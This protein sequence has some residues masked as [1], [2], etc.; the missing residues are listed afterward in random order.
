MRAGIGTPKSLVQKMATRFGR[1]P[2]HIALV[3]ALSR[4]VGLWDA[5]AMSSSAPPGSL[6]VG[7]LTPVLFKAWRRGG[8]WDEALE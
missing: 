1:E 5:S 4:A 2:S 8:A 3:I 7:D 6:S